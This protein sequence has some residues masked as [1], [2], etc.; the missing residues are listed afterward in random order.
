MPSNGPPLHDYNNWLFLS[1]ENIV[2]YGQSIGTVPTIDL[3][4]RYEV[5]AVILHSPLASGLRV[6]C[7]DTKK[8]W[9]FDVFPSI[10]KIGTCH[11]Y[12]VCPIFCIVLLW[13]LGFEEIRTLV[14]IVL[15]DLLLKFGDE[16]KLSNNWIILS[17][18][19]QF[20]KY[21]LQ[22]TCKLLPW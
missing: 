7:P 16:S 6:A 1:T 22:R 3:A 9:C 20:N 18:C 2:L 4:S 11:V 12:F 21:N 19:K 8:T 5:R 13:S 15:F 10:E 17:T 14:F